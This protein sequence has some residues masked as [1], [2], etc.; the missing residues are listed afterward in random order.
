MSDS[1]TLD[2][3]ALTTFSALRFVLVVENGSNDCFNLLVGGP[4]LL[5]IAP[6]RHG[7]TGVTAVA[8]AIALF[9]YK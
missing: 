3:D 6:L 5:L 4:L 7:A 2:S 1:P 8:M 9:M